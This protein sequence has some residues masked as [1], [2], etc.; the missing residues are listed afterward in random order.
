MQAASNLPSTPPITCVPHTCLWFKGR[1]DNRDDFPRRL[2]EHSGAATGDAHVVLAAYEQ[3]GDAF[4]SRLNGDFALAL[5]DHSRQRLTLAR[6]IMASQPLYYCPL[7]RHVLFASEIKCLLAHRDVSAVPDEDGLA[8]LVLDYWCDEHRTCFRG[9]Y[10]VPPGHSVVV[11]G[12]LI[13]RRRDWSF[14]TSASTR[15]ASFAE[16]RDEF[17]TLFEEAVRRRLRASRGV[18]IAVSGGVDSSSIFCQAAH[19]SARESLPIRLRGISLTFPSGTPASE[20][21]LLDDVE[22]MYPVPIIRLPVSEYSFVDAVPSTV[23]CV[24]TPAAVEKSHFRIADTARQAGCDV[25]LSGFFGDQLL[26]DRFYL[27]DVARRGR[28]LKIRHDL[29][30]CA[31][32]M[33]DVDARLFVAEFWKRIVREL[34]PRWLFRLVKRLAF[35]PRASRRYPTWFSRTFRER[36]VSRASTRFD[37]SQRFETVHAKHCYRHAT[38]GHYRN[39]VRCERAVAEANGVDLQYPFRDRDLV[40]FLLTVPGEIVNWQGIPKRLLRDALRDLLP[41]SV[42][43]RR[44]KA[45]FTAL[46]NDATRRDAQVIA[47]WMSSDSLAVVR[48]FAEG[49]MIERAVRVFAE[50]RGVDAAFPGWR[51]SDLAALEAWLRYIQTFELAG[52]Q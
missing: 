4:V 43:N 45:D 18:A 40:A 39:V 28:F 34:P 8:E 9:I 27:V 42:R 19:L 41:P 48:G 22:R 16:C 32:W 25:L 38:A 36:A 12:D 47:S 2:P 20:I 13:S 51:C 31:A 3:Y 33:T 30:E 11:V 37:E 10:S 17:R 46:E 15:R 7:P 50:M 26:S 5:I 21:E 6:D 49:A 44:W 52:Q 35:R 24:D 14:D 23:R 29:R 1:L